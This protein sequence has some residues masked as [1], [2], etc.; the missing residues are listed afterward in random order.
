MLNIET[1]C[2]IKITLSKKDMV[3]CYADFQICVGSAGD[4]G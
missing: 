4:I 3:V 1:F 2:A